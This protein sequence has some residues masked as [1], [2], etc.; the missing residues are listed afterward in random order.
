MKKKENLPAHFRDLSPDEI[1]NC[2]GGGFAYDVGRLIRFA[3]ISGPN[4]QWTPAAIL[5]AC[6]VQ[7]Q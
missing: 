2:N 6:A 5:D 4:G 7:C 3:I 1:L